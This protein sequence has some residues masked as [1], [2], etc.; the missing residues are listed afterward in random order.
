[1]KNR[2]KEPDAMATR[3]WHIFAARRLCAL[4]VEIQRTLCISGRNSVN[5]GSKNTVK[6][7]RPQQYTSWR[8]GRCVSRRPGA[9]YTGGRNM[10]YPSGRNKTFLGGQHTACTG[11]QNTAGTGGLNTACTGGQNTA[12][13]GGQNTACTGGKRSV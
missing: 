7:C 2:Q 6:C 12:C 9:V 8:I 3:P 11:D 1:M 13:T 5:P 4:E 10:L